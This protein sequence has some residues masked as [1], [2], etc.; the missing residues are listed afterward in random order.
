MAIFFMQRHAL[1]KSR[2]K[3]NSL[4]T[5]IQILCMKQRPFFPTFVLS[6]TNMYISFA[7][8]LICSVFILLVSVN[9]NLKNFFIPKNLLLSSE[10]C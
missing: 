10:K 1:Y 5:A 9:V 6:L 7:T 8:V 2:C 3:E 4:Q